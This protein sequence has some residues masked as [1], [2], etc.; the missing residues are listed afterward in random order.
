MPEHEI[1]TSVKMVKRE[2]DENPN[3]KDEDIQK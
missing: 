2:E 1:E 3:K